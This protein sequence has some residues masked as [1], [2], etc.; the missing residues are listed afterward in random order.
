MALGNL[1]MATFAPKRSKTA[2]TI[3]T[4]PIVEQDER[5]T[6]RFQLR[7]RSDI[8][9]LFKEVCEANHTDPSKAIRAFIMNVISSGKLEN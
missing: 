1:D 5:K 3:L 2:E 8:L 9:Q 7:L 4:T 6:N